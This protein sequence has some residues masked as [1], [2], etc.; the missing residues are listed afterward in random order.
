V[1]DFIE[2]GQSKI[3]GDEIKLALK[4]TFT[5][6][7]PLPKNVTNFILTLMSK[8]AQND[9]FFICIYIFQWFLLLKW[10]VVNLSYQYQTSMDIN[11]Q[12]WHHVWQM[13]KENEL[14]L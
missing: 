8:L 5:T 14:V 9:V 3:N 10:S 6:L 2:L 13:I 12:C 7:V 11:L 1:H 4:A